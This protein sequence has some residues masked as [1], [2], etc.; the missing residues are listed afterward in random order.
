M[1][2]GPDDE[3]VMMRPTSISEAEYQPLMP[4]EAPASLGSWSAA[5]YHQCSTVRNAGPPIAIR[6]YDPRV[7]SRLPA[8]MWRR[9]GSGDAHGDTSPMYILPAE[10]LQDVEGPEVRRAKFSQFSSPRGAPGCV[11]V[12][13]YTPKR[14]VREAR[15]ICDVS[16]GSANILIAIVLCCFACRD[17]D[18]LGL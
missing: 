5:D 14:S 11:L 12:H 10:Y 8:D 13:D 1:Q 17:G 16:S 9:S 15:L 3:L 4:A 18:S 7:A 2:V 6:H